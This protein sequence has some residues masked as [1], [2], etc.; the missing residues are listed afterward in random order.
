M[1]VAACIV[2]GG[3]V[4]VAA[5]Q[6]VAPAWTLTAMWL[7]AAG[8]VVGGVVDQV[9]AQAAF[10]ESAVLTLGVLMMATDAVLRCPAFAWAKARLGGWPVLCLTAF[11][12]LVSAAVNNIPVYMV[13]RSVLQARG[14]PRWQLL[15]LEH[16]C[17]LGGLL[18]P[19][20]TSSHFIA[21]DVLAEL[22]LRPV[23][24]ADMAPLTFPAVVAGFVASFLACRAFGPTGVLA[25][26]RPPSPNAEE[27]KTSSWV[28]AGL[29]A[30]VVASLHPDVIDAVGQWGVTAALL[31]VLLV[32]GLV[33]RRHPWGAVRP[34]TLAFTALPV[35]LGLAVDESGLSD[36]IVDA[37]QAPGG[38]WAA[39]WWLVAGSVVVLTQ[40][41]HNS[42]LVSTFL[43]AVV[44]LQLSQPRQTA[45]VVGVMAMASTSL[46]LP[47][48]YPLNELVLADVGADSPRPLLVPGLAVVGATAGTL[49]LST[50]AAT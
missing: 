34:S 41:V 37:V 35:L 12:V 29:G 21:N 9:D 13:M 28:L 43:P 36:A 18:T 25:A 42:V 33:D 7:L 19:I 32:F 4:V 16:A 24:V 11:A 38:G 46:L 39:V 17:A 48:G 14:A 31:A 1:T 22:G 20:G 50:W 44:G 6:F 10:G 3:L 45:L 27:K 15:H 47:T 26:P 40:V 49:W 23:S 5:T 8:C 2:G 30:W